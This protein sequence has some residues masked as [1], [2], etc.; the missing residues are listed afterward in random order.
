[1]K[2]A[3]IRSAAVSFLVMLLLIYAYGAVLKTLGMYQAGG[4]FSLLKCAFYRGGKA[5]IYIALLSI[6]F[7]LA[8]FLAAMKA[9]KRTDPRGLVMA[10]DAVEGSDH[11]MTEKELKESFDLCPS[12]SPSSL[13]LGVCEEGRIV[14]A[15]FTGPKAPST[16]NVLLVG[17]SGSRKTSSLI[18]PNIYSMIQSGFSVVVTD[19][20]G[21]I[22]SETAAAAKAFGYD[23]KVFD[24]IGGQF[25]YSDGW[26]VLRLVRE[27]EDPQVEA[28]TI[29]NVMIKNIG[30]QQ[31]DFWN[32]A[33]VNLLKLAIL[34][35]AR[36]EG[37][38]PI[39]DD[40][41]VSDGGRTM[42]EV[43]ALISTKNMG[44]HILSLINSN[45][46][47]RRL[48]QAPFDAWYYNQQREQIRSGL[49]TRFSIFQTRALTRILS[50]DE[51]DFDALNE[52][53]TLLY[54]MCSDRDTTYRSVLSLFVNSLFKRM[55]DIADASRE[56]T[57]KIPL[58]IVL[59]EARNIGYIPDLAVFIA[60]IRS[61]NIGVMMCYQNL[62]QLTD[63]YDVMRD[64]RFEWETIKNNCSIHLC[65][66]ADGSDERTCSH[67]SEKSG[68][69][70][71]VR[72]SSTRDV[73]SLA[74]R[75]LR[76]SLRE[77][78]GTQLSGRAVLLP[79]EIKDIAKDEVLI[80]KENAHPCI[81]KK[82]YY[83]DHPLYRFRV[84][85]EKGNAVKPSHLDRIPEWRRK[86]LM[87]KE[88]QKTGKKTELPGADFNVV[89][90]KGISKREL[91]SERKSILQ[92]IKN[93]LFEAE[94]PEREEAEDL[95]SK[96]TAYEKRRQ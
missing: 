74:P 23:I 33:N 62:S 49:A 43:Y 96:L 32:Q 58:Q 90:L 64:G 61:R 50:E 31:D 82:Y 52:R 67:F 92:N 70:T 10:R 69:M 75:N 12:D 60:T 77:K 71:I 5:V 57:L 27:A 76:A 46:A 91:E 87:R 86:E 53:K 56:K 1:M 66:G 81:K 39:S 22:Y 24:I 16:R 28:D 37:Y 19:P 36:A 89:M 78:E 95:R 18:I 15:P 6:L 94:E 25:S 84:K 35:V 26:D 54:L 20:K 83:V 14:T 55:A 45:D 2:R 63:T 93:E 17:T 73:S 9:M 68:R 29:V 13:I 3:A 21:E 65:C 8:V 79:S 80:F 34:T 51:I 40:A 44:E 47:N 7:G 30:V 41:S 11:M 48:L 88:E 59:E 85:D 42:A 4:S 72:R 38:T